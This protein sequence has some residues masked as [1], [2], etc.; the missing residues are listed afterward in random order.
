MHGSLAHD[1]DISVI[2]ALIA[3][4]S[5]LAILFALADGKAYPAGELAR[6]ARVSA[7]TGSAHLAR[8]LEAG[9][10]AVQAQGRHRYY[11][12]AN[13]QVGIVLE[14]ISVL[15]PPAPA[16]TSWQNDAAKTLR[17]ALTG[18]GREALRKE[19]GITL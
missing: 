3:D 18:C 6:L 8:L 17:F 19:L 12:L 13:E 16:L 4:K 9:L 15:A 2:G 1:P 14:S 11:R 7:Q 5:R 10:I